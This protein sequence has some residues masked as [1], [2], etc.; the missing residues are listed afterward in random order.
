M[1]QRKQC[2]SPPED[3][4]VV[5]LQNRRL[6]SHLHIR[7]MNMVISILKHNKQWLKDSRF[8]RPTPQN[9]CTHIITILI[10]IL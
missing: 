4:D 5:F 2:S 6:D 8:M 1:C 9:N 3:N 10:L 7:Y